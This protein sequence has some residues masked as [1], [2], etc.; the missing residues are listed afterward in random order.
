[1]SIWTDWECVQK[2]GRSGGTEF[3]TSYSTKILNE[4]RIRRGR[5]LLKI[6]GFNLGIGE[7]S[8]F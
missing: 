6:W 2:L 7:R 3:G 4:K 8:D 5:L 1:M